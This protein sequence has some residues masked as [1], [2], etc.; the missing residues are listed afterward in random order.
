MCSFSNF[1]PQHIVAKP[2]SLVGME[3]GTGILMI[4]QQRQASPSLAT[5]DHAHGAAIGANSVV[6]T[7]VPS[8]IKGT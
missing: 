3:S 2:A 8:T 5:Q 6:A 4:G 1:S 7:T